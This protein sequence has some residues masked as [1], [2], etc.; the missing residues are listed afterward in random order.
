MQFKDGGPCFLRVTLADETYDFDDA[1]LTLGQMVSI[2]EATGQVSAD[3]TELSVSQW[4]DSLLVDRRARAFQVLVWWLQGR[5]VRPEQV[6][7]KAGDIRLE[8]VAKEKP[9]APKAV[10]RVKRETVPSPS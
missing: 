10:A 3:G 8:L 9:K 7:P 4:L 1:E 5:T 2:E 6:N